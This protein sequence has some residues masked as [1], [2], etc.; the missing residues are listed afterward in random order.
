MPRRMLA[1]EARKRLYDRA[2]AASEILE[3]IATQKHVF[4]SRSNYSVI[5]EQ[6]LGD[7]N[8]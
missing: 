1:I 7:R 3:T 6:F 8:Q 4:T 2:I 5:T